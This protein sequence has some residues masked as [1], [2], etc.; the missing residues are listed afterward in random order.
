MN[1]VI[2]VLMWCFLQNYHLDKS[3]ACTHCV[4][5][6]FSPLTVRLFWAVDAQIPSR[7]D[8]TKEM[9]E[10]FQYIGLYEEDGR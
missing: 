1:D 4:A 8:Y 2:E 6:G 7:D 10:V 3:D 5:V 9:A